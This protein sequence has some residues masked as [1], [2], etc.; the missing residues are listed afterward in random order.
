MLNYLAADIK[1]IFRRIP[2]LIVILLLALILL[3]VMGVTRLMGGEPASYAN[4]I[5]TYIGVLSFAVGLTELLAVF[6]DD[7]RAKSMQAAIGIGIS[8]PQVV[9]SKLLEMMLMSAID[10]VFFGVVAVALVGAFSAGL[11]AGQL[12]TIVLELLVEWI[13][14]I[15]FTNLT[16]ILMFFMQS[17][18]LGTLLYLALQ[19]GFLNLAIG[20]MALV[21]GFSNLH[22]DSFTLTT[23][24]DAFKEALLA[25]KC[26][27]SALLGILVYFAAGLTASILVFRKRELEF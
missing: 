18:G 23:F 13:R 16:M 14:I 1:R 17:T 20:A 9:V 12:I 3:G 6:G 27:F 22:I 2:R 5:G 8:R 26:D 21:P 7:F 11:D 15:S 19:I 25:G 4:N 24:L 10:L